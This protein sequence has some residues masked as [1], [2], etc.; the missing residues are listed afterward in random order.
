MA[1]QDWYRARSLLVAAGFDDASYT[2]HPRQYE[3][4]TAGGKEALSKETCAEYL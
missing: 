2:L 4:S 1:M 3:P